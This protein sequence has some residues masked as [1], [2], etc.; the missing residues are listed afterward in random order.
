M[1]QRKTLLR[2]KSI[3]Q[4]PDFD[5][6]TPDDVNQPILKSTNLTATGHKSTNLGSTLVSTEASHSGPS[7]S[8]EKKKK[9]KKFVQSPLQGFMQQKDVDERRSNAKQMPFEARATPMPFE[10]GVESSEIRLLD[11]NLVR[12]GEDRLRGIDESRSD[13]D[14][15]DTVVNDALK[16]MRDTINDDFEPPIC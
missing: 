12:Q 13:V 8:D 10:D 14:S 4:K 16:S 2:S 9:Q 11:D 3:E 5:V 6:G 1:T 15:A 7:H